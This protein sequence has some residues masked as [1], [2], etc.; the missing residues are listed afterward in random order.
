MAWDMYKFRSADV[1]P[2]LGACNLLASQSHP[3]GYNPILEYYNSLFGANG[4]PNDPPTA[5]SAI[6]GKDS[7]DPAA[8]YVNRNTGQNPFSQYLVKGASSGKYD[9]VFRTL[10]DSTPWERLSLFQG[11]A[12][13]FKC[14]PDGF[15][16]REGV[17]TAAW[18]QF[19][20]HLSA[21]TWWLV[22]AETY[23][24]AF[25]DNTVWAMWN[26]WKL[27][28]SQDPVGTY[29][30]VDKWFW[31]VQFDNFD[32]NAAYQWGTTSGIIR[33][34]VPTIGYEALPGD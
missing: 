27:E 18:L 4:D 3:Y 20:F 10:W 2:S 31:D 7:C 16:P 6:L 1:R 22:N 12:G 21:G 17:N 26:L 8:M 23:R 29:T 24:Y 30:W 11:E 15:A 5:E 32:Q 28:N 13:Y 34:Q 25:G 33:D 14:P 9:S 19:L